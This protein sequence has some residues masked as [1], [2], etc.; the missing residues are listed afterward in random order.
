[1]LNSVNANWYD[2]SVIISYNS[3]QL[4]VWSSVTGNWTQHNGITVQL[5]AGDT[6]GGRIRTNGTEETYRK[7]TLIGSTIAAR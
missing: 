6:L 2:G 3:G 5:G 7:G 4:H 1:M